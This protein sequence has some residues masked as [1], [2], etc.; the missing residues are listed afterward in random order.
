MWKTVEEAVPRR[1]ISTQHLRLLLALLDT[2]CISTM[3]IEHSPVHLCQVLYLSLSQQSACALW[4]DQQAWYNVN[5]LGQL[6]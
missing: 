1:F 3:I 2:M 4:Q 6:S 5:R